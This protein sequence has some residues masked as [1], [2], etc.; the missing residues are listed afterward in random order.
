LAL[1][2]LLGSATA[3][4]GLRTRTYKDTEPGYV[5]YNFTSY[6]D[7]YDYN[8]GT[9]SMR[10][11]IND[12][13]WNS[14]GPIF[15]YCGNEGAIEMFIENSGFLPVLAQQFN[16]VLVFAE[17]RYFGE[18]LPY[19]DLSFASREYV[20]YLSP[21]QALADYAYLLEFLQSEYNDVPVIAFGGSY[22]GMLSA[23]FR[24]KYPHVVLGS[25]ASSAPLMH[26]TGAV[27][28]ELFNTIVTQDY[29]GANATC[30]TWIRSGFTKLSDLSQD[31][32]NFFELQQ[33]FRTCETVTN[34]N[35][36][37]IVAWLNNAYTYMAMTDYPYPTNFL[38]DMP[39]YPVTVAC[40]SFNNLT[41]QSSDWDILAAMRDAANVYY[42][43]TGGANCSEI[44]QMYENDLGDE[45]WDYLSCST[46]TMPIG[47]DGV[48]DMF[49][50]DPWNITEFNEYC[51]TN[52]G[53]IPRVDFVNLFFGANNDTSIPL[54]YA[55]NI[56]FANGKLDPWQS[57]S[58]LANVSDSVVALNIDGA[59]HHLDLR[60]PNPLDPASVVFARQQEAAYIEQWLLASS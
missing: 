58:V 42:N 51:M 2:L 28:P 39:G 57:G 7:H 18:S 37:M 44:D 30:P 20:K 26:F 53:E 54:R 13:F 1:L 10:Y 36:D 22:G 35:V 33:T 46:L 11:F 29:A 3:F 40:Q 15:F 17:H 6:I 24:M 49:L 14:T 19:G 43:Y 60:A 16:A 12:T 5:E 52:W 27:D 41:N 59:A 34:D 9:F 4:R 45:G 32:D 56:V 50:P 38:Q 47:S 21:H 25:I 8:A 48:N 31:P 55:S 23:W